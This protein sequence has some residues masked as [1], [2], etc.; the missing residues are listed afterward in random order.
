MKRAASSRS[1]PPKTALQGA[2]FSR[3]LPTP[4]GFNFCTYGGM[5]WVVSERFSERARQVVVLAQ[6]EARALEHNHIG[7]EHILLGLARE[8]EGLAARVLRS[9]DVT[10]E[11]LRAE[12]VGVSPRTI[13][14]RRDRSRSTHEARLAL[15][16]ALRE[17]QSLGLQRHRHRAHTARVGARERGCGCPASC[18]ASTPPRTRS[19]TRQSGCCRGRVH[20]SVPGS[21]PARG[22][23]IPAS[24]RSIG[25]GSTA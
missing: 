9:F 21:R 5:L 4:P 1:P 2:S 6:E 25:R 15:E 7:T 10:I 24:Y 17:A 16:L 23:P 22:T 14:P 11:R 18:S 19:V 20:E 13:S 12:V 3:F 8:E